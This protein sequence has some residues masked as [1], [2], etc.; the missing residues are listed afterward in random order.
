VTVRVPRAIIPHG[1]SVVVSVRT[2]PKADALITL[3]LTLA[4]DA[5]AEDLFG[6]AAT[7]P[8]LLSARY[9]GFLREVQERSPRFG[10]R[11]LDH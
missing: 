7:V 4:D 1:A 2:R 8:G 3:R 10:R 5:D 6:E 11:S 9:E